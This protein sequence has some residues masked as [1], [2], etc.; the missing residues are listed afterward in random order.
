MKILTLLTIAL[1]SLSPIQNNKLVSNN[2]LDSKIKMEIE[3]IANEINSYFPK[4]TFYDLSVSKVY[5][6]DLEYFDDVIEFKLD[7]NNCFYHFD[8]SGEKPLVVDLSYDAYSPYYGKQGI[9]IWDN[10]NYLTLEK[11]KIN[12]LPRKHTA[13]MTGASLTFDLNGYTRKYAASAI[14][15]YNYSQKVLNENGDFGNGC[16]PVSAVAIINYFNKLS[17]NALLNLS[18]SNLTDGN[19]YTNKARELYEELYRVMGTSPNTGTYPPQGMMGFRN[20]VEESLNLN[21]ELYTI[22]NV[23]DYPNYINNGYLVNI[24]SDKY[25]F[26]YTT[27]PT[28]KNNGDDVY[29][30]YFE[31]AKSSFIA[32]HTFVGYESYRYSDPI[33]AK[34]T[35]NFLK[36]AD[37]WGTSKDRFYYLD[38]TTNFMFPYAI[39]IY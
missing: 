23:N 14:D 27:P 12:Q 17:N 5:N 6:V 33:L 29:T 34:P 10:Y 13:N 3:T 24:T 22:T 19:I 39:K 35:I 36:I 18:S 32:S 9:K 16:T 25:Y 20:Y 11:S 2:E 8:S 38:E 15:F 31:Y 28:L 1:S 7:S 26:T 21:F 4:S 30:I 37:G